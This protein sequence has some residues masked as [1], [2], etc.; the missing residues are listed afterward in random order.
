MNPNQK[1]SPPTP[2]TKNVLTTE[3]HVIIITD[4]TKEADTKQN[5]AT[6]LL[7]NLTVTEEAITKEVTEAIIIKVIDMRTKVTIMDIGGIMRRLRGGMMMSKIRILE[8]II[9]IIINKEPISD[10][11]QNKDFMMITK[12]VSFLILF[13]NLDFRLFLVSQMEKMIL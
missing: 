4:M 13:K 3:D 8:S 2:P 7:D 1:T 12:E 9:D 5:P 6:S 10:H 11:H